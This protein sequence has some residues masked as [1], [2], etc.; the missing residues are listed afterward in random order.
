MNELILNSHVNAKLKNFYLRNGRWALHLL[1]WTYVLFSGQKMVKESMFSLEGFLFNFL[2]DNWIIIIFYYLYC[3]VWIPAY[4]KKERYLKFWISILAAFII[5]PVADMLFQ[6]K[7]QPYIPQ[8]YQDY[9][10]SGALFPGVA[11][12]FYYIYFAN[13]VS[14]S[15]F[16][17]LMETAEG[18]SNYKE[19]KTAAEDVLIHQKELMKTRINPEFVLNALDG[20][21]DLSDQKNEK[22]AQ[23]VIQFSD[24]LRYRLYKS[25]E[26]AIPLSEEVQ[27]L[28][29]IFD[30]QNNLFTQCC[31]LEVE[32]D[33]SD[34]QIQ[35]LSLVNMIEP[36]FNTYEADTEW[37]L[38]MYL[39]VEEQQLH[40]ALE[41]N[42]PYED[43]ARVLTEIKQNLLHFYD[44]HAQLEVEFM[45]YN[46]SIRIAVP[47]LPV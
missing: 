16:L 37:N 29:N 15:V 26:A 27:Q 34:K 30:L 1:Y 28:K 39:L 33:L 24:I 46:Y 7:F 32:G 11:L 3:L 38:I 13:F 18:L 35:T 5:M 23:S 31:V 40:I 4:F 6:V 25:K 36:I 20:L 22:A 47:L 21:A 45:A 9:D 44:E 8:R 42:T 14:F 2:F 17:F 19:E 12:K 43:K 10:F 41:W